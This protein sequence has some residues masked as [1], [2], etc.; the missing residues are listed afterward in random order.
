MGFTNGDETL[1][2]INP[3]RGAYIRSLSRNIVEYLRMHWTEQGI[4]AFGH[5]PCGDKIPSHIPSHIPYLLPQWHLISTGFNTQVNKMPLVL[6]PINYL[7]IIPRSS[8][9]EGY[10]LKH[11]GLAL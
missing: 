11:N 7:P 1:F 8:G 2:R 6:N 4:A 3:I 5:G 10:M 9:C